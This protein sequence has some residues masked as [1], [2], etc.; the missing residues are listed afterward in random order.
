[1]ATKAKSKSLLI[2]GTNFLG[3]ELHQSGTLQPKLLYGPM[4]SSLHP[5]HRILNILQSSPSHPELSVYLPAWPPSA[6]SW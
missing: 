6:R 1:M 2:K 5:Y 4:R 3:L